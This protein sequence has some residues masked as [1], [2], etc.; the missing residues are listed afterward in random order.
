MDN[1]RKYNPGLMQEDSEIIQQF[2]VRQQELASV[3]EIITENSTRSANQNVLLIGPRGRGKSMM[4]ARVAAELRI[5]DALSAQ[6][7]P[8]RFMEE[9][10]EIYTIGEFWLECLFY[11]GQEVD[12]AELRKEIIESHHEYS[13]IND[14]ERLAQRARATVKD[15]ST[16]LGKKLLLMVENLQQLADEV[17]DDFGWQL[18]QVLQT[19]PQI[20]LLATATVRFK[21]MEKVEQP[22]FELFSE[23]PL[24]PL[25]TD[26]CAR[27]WQ[28]ITGDDISQREIRP[29]EILTGGSPR[30]LTIVAGFAN[31]RSISELMEELV[32]LVDEHTEYFKSQ[33][34]PLPPKE[35]RIYIAVA[36]L[37]QPSTAREI[38][39]RARMDIRPVSSLLARL[40]KRGAI[41]VDGS[42]PR[43]KIYSVTERLYSIYYKLRRERS[44]SAVLH[45]LIQFMAAFYRQDELVELCSHWASEG[46]CHAEDGIRALV[47]MAEIPKE[48]LVNRLPEEVIGELF[49]DDVDTIN[50]NW[51]IELREIVDNQEWEKA[52]QFLDNEIAKCQQSNRFGVS[53]LRGLKAIIHTKTC[54]YDKANKVFSGIIKELP[55]KKDESTE[56][57]LCLILSKYA[58]SLM[59]SSE[60]E[61][62]EKKYK[63]VINRFSNSNEPNIRDMVSTAFIQLADLYYQ[64]SKYSE[65]IDIYKELITKY[66]NDEQPKAKLKIIDAYQMMALFQVRMEDNKSLAITFTALLA[67]IEKSGFLDVDSSLDDLSVIKIMESI[68]IAS[69]SLYAGGKIE[70]AHRYCQVIVEGYA[71]HQA[72]QEHF[73]AAKALILCSRMSNEANT[74]IGYLLRALAVSGIDIDAKQEALVLLIEIISMLPID[75]ALSLLDN[76]ADSNEHVIP[77]KVALQLE[78]GES[79]R[80]PQEILE[81]AKDVKA[82]LAECRAA[83]ESM[84][85]SNS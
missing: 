2:V 70:A 19:E 78:L 76:N 42:N 32:Y 43:K 55:E 65:A 48:K 81:V 53:L 25:T 59:K 64:A 35:R 73:I 57:V 36:D 79:P 31:H 6:W 80:V 75:D 40:E 3:I 22:F 4:L 51:M 13:A 84:A 28:N 26:E 23:I 49:T 10:H 33:L 5:N 29:L 52:H 77:L 41:T 20:M 37:W 34:D 85:E 50:F 1:I 68:Y 62:A 69:L 54:D 44:E 56:A 45:G 16:R 46:S 74:A 9:S 21:S 17:D 39:V 7:I 83:H 18:R 38:A 24:P 82:K 72:A 12:S 61:L 66:L 47:K 30:L 15:I 60:P 14:E 11:L 58:D 67:F 27:H 8:V 71:S 63:E